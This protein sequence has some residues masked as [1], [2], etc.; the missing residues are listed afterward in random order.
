MNRIQARYGLKS[1]GPDSNN[2]SNL[3]FPGDNIRPTSPLRVA[4]QLAVL[5]R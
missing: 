2:E 5:P 1:D 3:A 4:A